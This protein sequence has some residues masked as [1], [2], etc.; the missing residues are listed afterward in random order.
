M[1][2]FKDYIKEKEAPITVG[3]LPVHGAHSAEKPISVS[4]L[5]V[6]G[7]HAH[8]QQ[9]KESSESE[10]EPGLSGEEFH[11]KHG[12]SDEQWHKLNS[13]YK[14]H[15]KDEKGDEEGVHSS[16]SDYTHS[17]YVLNK[18]LIH[19]ESGKAPSVLSS[20]TKYKKLY[21]ETGEGKNGG[22]HHLANNE[23]SFKKTKTQLK[24]Q[25]RHLD[26]AI[27]SSKL[28]SSAVVYHGCG[29]DPDSYAKQHSK[30][31]IH[32]PAYT[33]TSTNS[34]AAE[35]FA[36]SN[37]MEWTR[38]KRRSEVHHVL[39]IHLPKGHTA[40]PL[41]HR[42]NMPNENEVLLKRGLKLKIGDKP[43][44]SIVRTKRTKGTL[45]PPGRIVHYWDAHPVE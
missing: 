28:K 4:E 34:E 16:I 9:I 15:P 33:S 7:S 37:K 14:P 23:T 3:E 18:N 39:R 20:H 27:G 2:R 32:L 26:H 22:S 41:L 5:P 38:D 25:I 17:S 43:T 12:L 8:K 21:N 44:H 45:K 10:A 29:F 1:K 13:S 36:N 19:H 11:Q 35:N 42:S 31:H 24:T 30:R 6:H 40:L